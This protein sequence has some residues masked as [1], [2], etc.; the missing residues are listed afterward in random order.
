MLLY[1]KAK[2]NQRFDKVE[3]IGN[4]WQI[5]LKAPAV[6]GKAN[7]Y[8]IEYLSEILKISKSKISLKKGQTSRIKC[9]EILADEKT[10]METLERLA[11]S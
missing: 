9:V 8:L 11:N 7:E 4:E 10:V 2:P 1:I 5:R 6:D 3:R